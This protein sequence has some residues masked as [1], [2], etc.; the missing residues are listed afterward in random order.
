MT[1]ACLLVAGLPRVAEERDEVRPPLR[2]AVHEQLPVVVATLV[3]EMTEEGAVVLPELDAH[4]FPLGVV[5]LL[6][7]DGDRPARVAGRHSIRAH[8]APATRPRR[9][10]VGEEG[11]AQ[12]GPQTAARQTEGVELMDQAPLGF[13]EPR[14]AL[15]VSRHAQV[16]DDLGVH[17]GVAEVP[18]VAGRHHA[19]A[20]PLAG[21][22][23]A[24][25]ELGRTRRATKA[26][27]AGVETGDGPAPGAP[28]H[29]PAATDAA[30]V[31]EVEPATARALEGAHSRAQPM[32]ARAVSTSMS[33]C[34]TRSLR[35]ISKVCMP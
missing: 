8:R 25:G 30:G 11:E 3:A 10:R 28:P 29:R 5:G 21:V 35:A 18:G 12:R 34:F 27:T 24:L 17:A 1:L 23:R 13:F 15:P 16:G 33:P 19:V 14:P 6:H 20:H 7:V 31:L 32:A 26:A 22:V 4:P 2:V 9:H